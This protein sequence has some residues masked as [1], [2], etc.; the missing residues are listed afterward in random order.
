MPTDIA[1]WLEQLDLGKYAALFIENDI[2]LELLP[3]LSEDDLR[4]LGLPLGVADLL[5]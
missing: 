5:R 3:R 4:E 1:S 2:R